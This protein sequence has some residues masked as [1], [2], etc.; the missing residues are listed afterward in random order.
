VVSVPSNLFSAGRMTSWT[1]PKYFQGN[2]VLMI[3]LFVNSDSRATSRKLFKVQKRRKK[4][5]KEGNL[6]RKWL[7]FKEKIE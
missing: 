3:R 6:V 2:L 7:F 4:V 1:L 5:K